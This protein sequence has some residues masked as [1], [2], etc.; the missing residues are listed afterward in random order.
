[1]ATLTTYGGTTI[2]VGGEAE[3][4]HNFPVTV[5]AIREPDGEDDPG[6]V[7]IRHSWGETKELDPVRLNAYI[8]LD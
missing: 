1:M 4:D 7:T 5:T 6:T 8:S 2:P 3:L